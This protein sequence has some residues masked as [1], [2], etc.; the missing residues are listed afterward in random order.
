MNKYETIIIIDPNVEDDIVDKIVSD[1]HEIISGDESGGFVTKTDNWGKKKLAYDV[2]ANKEGTYVLV[3]YETI[4]Q[5]VQ[6][7]ER[8]C[9]L[10]ELVI[11]Y[12]TVRAEELPE[13]RQKEI[14]RP[15]LDD[16]DDDDIIIGFNDDDDE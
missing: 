2:G 3:N 1:I 7:L 16:D 10:S 12:M 15:N 14:T 8:Y 5:Q 9:V 6:R 11:K 4:P 13:P